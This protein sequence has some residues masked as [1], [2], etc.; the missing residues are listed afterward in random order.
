MTLILGIDPGATGAA[1]LVGP[2]TGIVY[3]LLDLDSDHAVTV[4]RLDSARARY[5]GE[6]FFCIIERAQTM[7]K[8]N[9]A[10]QGRYM[11]GYGVIQGWLHTRCISHDTIRP[12]TWKQNLGLSKA[13]KDASLTLARR[14][15]PTA[16]L[17]LKKHHN[18]AEALLI[19]EWARRNFFK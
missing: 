14:L 5:I 1:A 3:E 4:E 2:D 12:A 13:D 18:R 17:G 11:E 6:A 9:V 8:M 7:P 15:F 10:A 16:E 19:A